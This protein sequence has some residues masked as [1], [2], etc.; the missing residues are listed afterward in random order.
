[1]YEGDKPFAQRENKLACELKLLKSL[2]LPLMTAFI[3]LSP[4]VNP[5]GKTIAFLNIVRYN[6]KSSAIENLNCWV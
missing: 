1:M 3:A 6:A 4:I 5:P 2:A